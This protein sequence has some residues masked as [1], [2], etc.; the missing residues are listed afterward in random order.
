MKIAN[1]FGCIRNDQKGFFLD[2]RD[3]RNSL[4]ILREE[5][6]DTHRDA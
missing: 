1:E 5:R 2:R 6:S 4:L 3:L